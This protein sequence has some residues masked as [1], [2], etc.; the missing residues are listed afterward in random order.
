MRYLKLTNV[1]SPNID[2][3]ELNDFNGFLCTSFQKLGI[4]RKLDFLS[5]KNRQFAVDNKP[6]FNKYDL[7]IEILSKYSDY[8]TKYKE[9]IT[10]IDR[11][12]KEGLR[13]YFKPN[14]ADEIKYCLCEVESLYKTEKMQPISLSLIQCSLW[15][16][17]EKIIKTAQSIEEKEN[18]FAFVDKEKDGYYSAMFG[19]DE[20]SNQ[21]CVEFFGNVFTEAII[22]NNSYNEIPLNINIYGH[23]VNPVVSLFRKGEDSA[24]MSTQI[25]AKI[26]NDYYIEI[27]AHINENGVWYVNKNTG[28]RTPY[29]DK[30][31]SESSPYFYID[32][33]EYVITVVDDGKN[34]C[35]IDIV[36]SEEYNE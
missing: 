17:E 12:K 4:K 23:C 14:Q 8:D 32:N 36:F 9:L 25:N 18:I 29:D 3:I 15:F 21:Y 1:K 5:I 33:G 34:A 6:D 20:K 26:D 22:T 16:S 7:T 28:E 19:F 30:V 35:E 10:F 24:I 13:L 11:N 2:F 27:N 31:N